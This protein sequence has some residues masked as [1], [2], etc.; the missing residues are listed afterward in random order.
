MSEELKPCPFC[1][2]HAEH[3]YYDGSS[4][5]CASCDVQT[6]VFAT[7]QEAIEAWNQRHGVKDE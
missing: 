3:I 2:G 6:Q 4:V 5:I 7:E 1:G